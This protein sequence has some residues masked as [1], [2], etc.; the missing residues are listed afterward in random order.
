MEL[1]ELLSL[2]EKEAKIQ[3]KAHNDFLKIEK[4]ILKSK[5][6]NAA[7]WSKV[8]NCREHQQLYIGK[9]SALCKVASTI[10][11][12]LNLKIPDND[13]YEHTLTA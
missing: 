5:N 1:Q 11:K 9:Y 8:T 2:I 7:D 13:Y 12:E 6:I 3:K 10:R 4:K